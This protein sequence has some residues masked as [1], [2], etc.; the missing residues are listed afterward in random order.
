MGA[1]LHVQ[2]RFQRCMEVRGAARPWTGSQL[3]R[4]A[5]WQAAGRDSREMHVAG[6]VPCPRLHAPRPAVLPAP[7]SCPSRLLT[8]LSRPPT[9]PLPLLPHLP[10]AMGREVPMAVKYSGRPSMASTATGFGE[11]HAQEQVGRGRWGAAGLCGVLG[12]SCGAGWWSC[13]M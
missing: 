5:A 4:Q 6:M 9:L 11:V 2:P 8:L 3:L 12:G 1:Y 7:A 10:Q 13:V